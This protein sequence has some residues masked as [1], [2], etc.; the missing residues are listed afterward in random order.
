M[1]VTH[2][3]ETEFAAGFKCFNRLNK[4]IKVHKD[5]TPTECNNNVIYKIHCKDCT[6]SYVGQTKRQ[7]KTRIH[8]HKINIRQHTSNQSVVSQHITEY[9]HNI[10][11]DN[12][13][14]LDHETNYYKRLI[15]ETIHIKKQKKRSQCHGR[16]RIFRQIIFSVTRILL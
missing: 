9:K 4:F 14:I 13:K 2:F 7:L 5:I 8:E 1:F 10:D 16:H 6:A 15:A 3:E 11:W 12:V